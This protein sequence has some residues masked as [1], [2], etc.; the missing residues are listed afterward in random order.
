[1]KVKFKSPEGGITAMIPS[2]L[3]RILRTQLTAKPFINTS[4]CEFC[5]ACV[6]NCSACAIEE[7]GESL[8][9]NDGKCIQCY[10]CRELCPKNAVE[11]KKSLLLKLY[12]EIKAKM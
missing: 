3:M 10:C 7:I 9:I 6:L 8:K 2:F 1:V 11:I 12:T 4:S 5:K